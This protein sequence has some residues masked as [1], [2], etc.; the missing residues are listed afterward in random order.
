LESYMPCCPWSSIC[1]T[2]TC[3][4][5]VIL[6]T[7]L[8]IRKIKL[9]FVLS[10]FRYFQISSEKPANLLQFVQSIQR[11]KLTSRLHL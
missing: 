11:L 9:Y 4:N 8:Q 6:W 3:G 5:T 7:Y 2:C 1:L 10:R